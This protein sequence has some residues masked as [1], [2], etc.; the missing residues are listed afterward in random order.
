MCG[1]WGNKQCF[2][3][4]YTLYST[5]SPTP[6]WVINGPE[7]KVPKNYVKNSVTIQPLVIS[8][9]WK[10]CYTSSHMPS[11]TDC[12]FFIFPLA[13]L[14][15]LLQFIAN[16]WPILCYRMALTCPYWAQLRSPH[17]SSLFWHK[18]SHAEELYSSMSSQKPTEEEKQKFMGR[19]I[20][21]SDEGPSKGHGG[22]FAA[23]IV[24]DGKIIGNLI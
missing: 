20:E 17:P 10:L 13:H 2:F 7:S 6:S 1:L 12:L 3:S 14:L 21:L 15:L 24:K 9:L 8:M 19:A 5:L 18:H 23:V 11:L 22:P 16:R 4:I